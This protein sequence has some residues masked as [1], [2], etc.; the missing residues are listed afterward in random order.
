MSMV[1]EFRDFAVKGNVIHVAVGVIIGAGFGKIV[2]SFVDDIVMPPIGLILGKVDFTSLYLPLSEK[3]SFGLALADAKK[4][5]PVLAYG[6]FINNIIQFIILAFVIFLMIK[7]V[8][9]FMSHLDAA[10]V[11]VPPSQT[12]TLLTEIRDL[13]KTGHKA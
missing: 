7:A 1:K 5:G 10:S 12:E 8:N 2:T 3:V 4:L 13:M 11:N 9:R 6:S